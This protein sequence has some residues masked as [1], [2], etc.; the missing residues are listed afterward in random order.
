MAD[1]QL[2]A[3]IQAARQD[4][5]LQARLST[6]AAADADEVATIAQETGFEVTPHDLVN[7]AD[8]LLVEYEDEDYFM[9]PRWWELGLSG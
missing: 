4:E 9:K 3:F 1:Q 2:Q 5:R 6:T 8:G 7:H